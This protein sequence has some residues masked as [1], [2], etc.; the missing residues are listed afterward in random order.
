MWALK[1]T[2][3]TMAATRRG[4]GKAVPHSLNGR[5]VPDR[6]EGSFFAFGDDLGQQFGAAGVELDIAQ[7]VQQQEVQA[8][9]AADDTGQL[10][11]VGGFGEFVDQPGGGGVTDRRPC[12]Q[13][14]SPRP[15]SRMLLCPVKRSEAGRA[16]R[17]CRG[18]P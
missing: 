14:A 3:S 7:L 13:A 15:M 9:V 16:W 11:L 17:A 10:P 1:V 12:S 8:A 4:S 2:R 18:F 6:D 5:F